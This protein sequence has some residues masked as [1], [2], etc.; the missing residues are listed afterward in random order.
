M[1]CTYSFI[2]SKFCDGTWAIGLV[3]VTGDEVVGLVVGGFTA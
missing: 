2:L 1:F 3:R